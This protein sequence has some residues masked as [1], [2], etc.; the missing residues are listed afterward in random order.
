M[1]RHSAS[2][3]RARHGLPA[4]PTAAGAA[5]FVGRVGAMALALGVGAA[6][7]G[8]AGIANADGTTDHRTSGGADAKS[9]SS[10]KVA[11]G[12]ADSIDGTA[13]LKLRKPE[14]VEG[15]RADSAPDRGT[16]RRCHRRAHTTTRPDGLQRIDRPAAAALARP[17][18]AR[19]DAVDS[20]ARAKVDEVT[21]AFRG[22]RPPGVVPRQT[23]DTSEQHRVSDFRLP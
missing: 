1:G 11:R 6:I 18:T 15:A 3:S 23:A 9:S 8:G 16:G 4:E 20:F 13:P 5:M 12:Q 19:D 2:G 14:A 22:D 10:P 17:V 21:A 7:A